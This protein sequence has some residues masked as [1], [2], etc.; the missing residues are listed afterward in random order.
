[1]DNW[2]H[3]TSNWLNKVPDVTL[4]VLKDHQDCK[5]RRSEKPEPTFWPSTQASAKA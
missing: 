4:Y 2:L 5:P 1:M 3:P